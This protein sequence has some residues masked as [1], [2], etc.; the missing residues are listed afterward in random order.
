MR[1]Y[2]MTDIGRYLLFVSI[3]KPISRPA[4]QSCNICNEITVSPRPLADSCRWAIKNQTAFYGDEL[5]WLEWSEERSP[6]FAD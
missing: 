4:I 3:K 5:T 6:S 1:K 2:T